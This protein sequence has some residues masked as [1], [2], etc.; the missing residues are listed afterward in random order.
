MGKYKK[1]TGSF[2][3]VDEAGNEHIIEIWTE[4]IE[5][6]TRGD[7]NAE[8]EGL[9]ELRTEDGLAVNRIEKGKYEVV[10]TGQVLRSQHPD[11]P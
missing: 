6:L 3:A 2:V 1:R 11:A 10:Q 5:T 9:K 8:I 4:M 7:P